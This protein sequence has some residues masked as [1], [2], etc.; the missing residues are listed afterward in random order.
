MTNRFNQNDG[1]DPSTTLFRILCPTKQTVGGDG[2]GVGEGEGGEERRRGIMSH[3]TY[4][5]TLFLHRMY[6]GRFWY[7]EIVETIRRLLL[8]AI[9]SIVATG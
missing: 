9:I 8:T 5:E 7:W 6:E 1:H 4:K 2:V 3:I